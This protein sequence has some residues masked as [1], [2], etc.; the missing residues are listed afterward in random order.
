MRLG[1]PYKSGVG[2][3]TDEDELVDSDREAD[4]LLDKDESDAVS[5]WLDPGLD[6][7]DKEEEGDQ[8]KNG[9]VAGKSQAKKAKYG[10]E[11]TKDKE[12]DREAAW[13]EVKNLVSAEGPTTFDTAMSWVLS[14]ATRE[15]LHQ[16][17]GALNLPT[18]PFA[19]TTRLAGMQQWWRKHRSMLSMRKQT[20]VDAV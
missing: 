18:T 13:K 8:V 20:F 4:G 16:L 19:A 17:V 14:V 12:V 3:D 15:H 7:D 5:S 9:G 11:G 1:R 2:T 6:G 10:E